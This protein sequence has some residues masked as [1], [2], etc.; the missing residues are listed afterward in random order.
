MS[1]QLTDGT[2]SSELECEVCGTP[3]EN[4]M[5]LSPIEYKGE[6]VQACPGCHGAAGGDA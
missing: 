6:T 5:N 2:D 1:E 3:I 4:E